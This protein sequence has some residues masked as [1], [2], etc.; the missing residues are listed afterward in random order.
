M[1]RSLPL[2]LVLPA[3]GG[4]VSRIDETTSFDGAV[5]RVVLDV[6]AADV[7]VFAGD[8]AALRQVG[9][10]N[11]DPPEVEATLDGGTL[12]LSAR[13]PHRVALH[14]VC[15]LDLELEVPADVALQADLGAGDLT[16]DGIRGDLDVVFGSGDVTGW[17]LTP[18]TAF[19]EGGAGDLDLELDAVPDEVDL[20]T[21]A[22]DVHLVLPHAAY[23]VW[24]DTGSG[25]VHIG[26]IDQVAAAAHRLT[27][28]TGSGDIR[29]EGR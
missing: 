19:V 10:Y 14:S 4:E 11:Q 13:C 22:G 1:L 5:D 15:E 8:G 18:A 21:G 6:G 2:L 27:L 3:C 16:L 24:T 29:V 17:S 20:S 23:A 7:V 9:R 12:T 26:G 25:E 28:E